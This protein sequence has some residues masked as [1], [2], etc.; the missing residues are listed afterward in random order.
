MVLVI[1]FGLVKRFE[2]EFLLFFSEVGLDKT[3][4]EYWTEVSIPHV[5]SSEE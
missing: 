2:L 1:V 3:A 4:N 5:L